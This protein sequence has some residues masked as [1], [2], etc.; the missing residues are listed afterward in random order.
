MHA[1]TKRAQRIIEAAIE[2]F[3][4][5]GFER[6]STRDIAA[7]AGVNA[8]AL[9]YYFEN[10]E[11]VYRACA[12]A[13]ADDAWKIFGPSIQKAHPA[14]SPRN[15]DT[16]PLID[17]FIAHSG[18]DRGQGVFL[19]VHAI[20]AA[21]FCAR[22]GGA[23]AADCLANFAGTVSR[24][25]EPRVRRVGRENRRHSRRR[26]VNAD[27]SD[28]SARSTDR[29]PHCP[30]HDVD[31]T[32]LGGDRCAE[33]RIH[34]DGRARANACSARDMERRTG[35]EADLGAGC[36]LKG[37]VLTDAGKEPGMAAAS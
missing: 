34:H 37:S 15:A 14:R 2:L 3:G 28:Q 20:A 12:E 18:S 31:A 17:A 33:E 8:P 10:K 13:L 30:P 32:R 9:Q 24:T 26:S 19:A 36:A 23:R 5:H 35:D 29:L 1:A 21:I 4:E 25:V 7:R 11:G 22:A 27:S 6:A 16:A